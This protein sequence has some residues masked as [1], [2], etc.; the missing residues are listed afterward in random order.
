MTYYSYINQTTRDKIMD[1]KSA[2]RLL[3]QPCKNRGVDFHS[4]LD[5]QGL[6][7]IVIGSNIYY[8]ISEAE[9]ALSNYK[10]IDMNEPDTQ[11]QQADRRDEIARSINNHLI[12]FDLASLNQMT[13]NMFEE[14]F[15]DKISDG[16]YFEELA[17]FMNRN[18]TWRIHSLDVS[19][20]Y[21]DHLIEVGAVK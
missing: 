2:K 8:S 9:E 5:P 20:D 1:L 12:S 18:N 11:E 17:D 4:G 21:A 15:A 6:E 14:W 19:T 13:G 3:E 16:D 10:R 7:Y